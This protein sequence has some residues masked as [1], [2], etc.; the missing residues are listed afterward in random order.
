[1]KAEGKTSPPWPR[2][3]HSPVTSRDYCHG[4]PVPAITEG[5]G[6]TPD[7]LDALVA[8][9]RERPLRP[10]E[11]GRVPPLRGAR[12]TQLARLVADGV[13]DGRIVDEGGLLRAAETDLQARTGGAAE[14]S[15]PRVGQPMRV[16]A[17][18][19]ESVVRT[20]AT[21]PYSER[22]AFQVAALRF[23]RDRDWAHR[24]RSMSRFC[25]LPAVGDGPDW[26]ITSDILRARHAAEAVPADVWLDELEA[27]LDGADAV[28]AYNGLELDFPLLDEERHRAGRPPLAGYELIDGLLLALSLW[29]N[30][31]NNH[32]LA[33]LAERLSVDL[34]R[35]TWH[36]AL[37][38][39]RLLATVIWAGARELRTWNPTLVDLLL[40]VC[41]DSP[42][43]G[44]LA[45]LARTTPAGGAYDEDT[46]AALVGG[47][48]SAR[49]VTPRRAAPPEDP[50]AEPPSRPPI[51][52]PG[53]IVGD[54][55]RVDPHLLAEVANG[56]DL[57]RRA[58]QGQMAAALADWLPA[59]HGGLV[60]AP[61][62]TGKSLVLLAAGLEW[63]RSAEGRRAVIATH[64]KQLQSQLARDV[65]RLVDAGIDALAGA[66]DLVKGA[67]NRLSLRGLTLGLVDACQP[68]LRRGSLGE[69]AQR[70]LLAYLTVRF[71]T[72]ARLTERWLGSSVDPV[73]VPVIFRRTTRSRVAYWLAGLSQN[74]QGEYRA[75]PNLELSLHTSR[76]RE[77]LE[78]S[79]IVIANHA[80]LLAHRDALAGLDGELLVLVDE[81]H[82]MEGAATEALSS[83]FDYQALERV[84][85]EIARFNA[86]A[87]GHPAVARLVEMARQ[88]R[89]FL[90]AEVLPSSAL[91][92][93]DQLAEPAAEPGRRAVTLASPYVPIRGGAPIQALRHS[94]TRARNYL[95]FARRM[96][97]WWAADPGGLDAAGRWAAERFR[98]LSST[99]LAQEEALDAILS[100]LDVLLGPMRRRVLRTPG[101]GDDPD[102]DDSPPDEGHDEALASA[103]DV[104]RAD[105]PPHDPPAADGAGGED[106]QEAGADLEPAAD[107]ETVTAVG[108]DSEWVSVAEDDPEDDDEIAD[109]ADDALA[110]DVEAGGADEGLG[111]TV[112]GPAPSNRVVWMAEA[113]SPDVA[114]SKRNLHFSVTT[115]PIALGDDGTWRDFLAS[116]P[117]LVLTS[118]TLRVSGSWEFIR[119]RLG[120]DPA[121][122]AV[123]L[124]TPFDHASRAKLVCLADFPSWAEHPARAMRTIAHQLVGWMGLAGRPHLDGGVAGGA[125][126]LTTSRASAAGIAE[127]AAPGL[128][129][130]GVPVATAETL[131][132]ARA[133]DTFAS[134]GG[135]L[136]GTRGL[137]QGVDIS[138]PGRL[139]LVWINK[140]PF[141]PFADPVVAARRAHALAG[142]VAARAADPE[143]AADEAYY[144]PLA[145]LSL[146]QAVGR[147]I[148]TTSHRG[149]I[150]I[151]DNK[152]SGSDSRRRM[153]RRVF[154]GSLEDGLRVDVGADVGGGNVRSML[155]GWREIIDFARDA[156]II[157]RSAADAALEPQALAGFVDLPEMVA[158]RQLTYSPTEAASARAADPDG[159][160]AEVVERS[161]A[162]A[163]VLAGAPVILRD[164]QRRAIAAIARGDDLL[165]LLPTGFGKSFCYQLP[166]LVL[167]G[168]TVVVSPLVSLMV[169]Q[170]MG[171]GATIGSMVRA[172]TG[173]MRESNSRLGKTQVAE[174]LR[175]ETD[176]HDIRLIYLSPE[177]LA[178]SR[179]RDLIEQA[180]EAGI[181]ARIAIDEAHTLVSW[182]DDFRPSFRRMD[183]WLAGLKA[184]HPELA[185]AAFTAT[186]NRTVREGLRSR[187]FGL[188]AVEPDGGD[189]AGFE[190]V[191]ANPLRADLAIWRRRLAPGGPNAVAGLIEAI[192][193][194]LDEHAI[195]Y[196]TTVKEVERTYAAVR[197]YLGESS[198]DRVLRYHGR[199]STA[200][201]AA[202]AAAFK[203][204][205]R[206]GDDDFRPMIV[207]ATSAFGLGVDRPDIRAVFVISP[208]ADLAAMYQQLGR[209]GRDSSRKVPGTDDVPTNAAMA[210]VT[211]RSWRTV[212]WMA[213]QDIGIGTLRRLADRLLGAVPPGQVA[214][215]DPETVAGE[216]MVEDVAAGRLAKGALRSARAAEEYSA[217]AV[218]A[219]AALGAVSGVE[220][221]GDVP[222]RVRVSPGEVA[223][224]DEVWARVIDRIV[225]NP[226]ALTTGVELAGLH[227]ELAG[228]EGVGGYDEV[229]TDLT[230]LWNGLAVAHDRGWLDVS[231]QVTRARLVVYRTLSMDRPAGFDSSV[232]ARNTRV[233][234]ELLELRRWFDDSSCCAHVGFAA[235][236]GVDGVPA[237]AC[238]TAAVRC[239]WHWNDAATVAGDPTEAPALHR[240]FFTPR[241]QPV[242]ATATGRVAFERRLRRHI[243]DLLWHEYRGLTAP[244]L[245]RVLNGE[246]SWYSRRLGRRRRL[247]PSLLHHRLRGAMIGVR[248]AAVEAALA[249][250]AADGAVAQLGD[251]RWR[252]V[253]H[254]AADEARGARE[255]ARAGTAAGGEGDRA[256]GSEADSMDGGLAVGAER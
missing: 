68:A 72:A 197:D 236:F 58:A 133:V 198:A 52:V 252:L 96:L 73:D 41:D 101:S 242:A 14:T 217:A 177:R 103:L 18:D 22:R 145:A 55:G 157:E 115:S 46:V 233:N 85:A 146:R 154:L 79:P 254:I 17:I 8:A 21:K 183:R 104:D 81:A 251:G 137:W 159:F 65:Q 176:R 111:S 247:W 136:I 78:A 44:L 113:D 20:T 221:L 11:L 132:N 108:V 2:I 35:Y 107:D 54:D 50:D 59:G 83:S 169:D 67:S 187:L 94:L 229:A 149:V 161:Q 170:A 158:I 131:G 122:P 30:P 47:E 116:T 213:T 211:H 128:S 165:A 6:P 239:S 3:A 223:C 36:E 120:L 167:P 34:D 253:E 40:T 97:A 227:V 215:V 1:M 191:A 130:A 118:G 12:A 226:D 206:A 69:P 28:V 172:L 228:P 196:C 43:W 160:A 235:H 121:V 29:P 220:D 32:R 178:D 77:A 193:A 64:T 224:A 117:R 153:Y 62:G 134:T 151:S 246:D 238:A 256:R 180:V 119:G 15:A 156:G 189:P 4:L 202:V 106:A 184:T 45:D 114:R 125:M 190:T 92:A 182:G 234:D 231:Q 147:L 129:A 7:F 5:K 186:A 225:V 105:L 144:L 173:P 143:R 232:T 210:L 212:T 135:V 38:D 87:D 84:P 140:L 91:R 185:V 60:E 99:I 194:R 75:D 100:D 214:A 164:E 209:A 10:D 204:A 57:E 155:D 127:V 241:P 126:V 201:K 109:P 82:E 88:L 250:L 248:L 142:A 192:V 89:R 163:G 25:E 70:E 13:A 139:R 31:P 171:L 188:P 27:V 110:D 61:T 166:A 240:A 63:V 249:G 205:G 175:G 152:L 255:A 51:M 19:F 76:V 123:E 93:L 24:R 37:S 16:V 199:L 23:G 207:V 112:G 53:R 42:A 208:P 71:I 26:L 203:T 49:S 245:R 102:L 148:R 243:N 150:V 244:M 219:L 141:A 56:R 138:D 33:V 9:L 80:L 168:V 174:T 179:F 86:E 200:E 218:R 98:A 124:D 162:V 230:E 195:F 48:L 95:E 90:D 216:Q 74:E 181:V 237:G 222:D 66:T 39:C